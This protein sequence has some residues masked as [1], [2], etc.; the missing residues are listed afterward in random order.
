MEITAE[1]D[2]FTADTFLLIFIFHKSLYHITLFYPSEILIHCFLCLLYISVHWC[3]LLSVKVTLLDS[4]ESRLAEI[5][6]IRLKGQD[7]LCLWS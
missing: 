1:T 4:R 5:N 2:I 7:R 6:E 3:K